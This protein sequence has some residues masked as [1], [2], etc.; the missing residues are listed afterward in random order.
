M[1]D[2]P[3]KRA[4]AEARRCSWIRAELGVVLLEGT[5]RRRGS[6][7]RLRWV[8]VDFNTGRI[9]WRREHDKKRKEWVV[10]YPESL[11]AT[12]REFQRR[13]GT[14]GWARV[15]ATCRPAAVRAA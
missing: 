2:S 13:L 15:P 3:G 4:L 5:G 8:D 10:A 11:L 1:A 7:T 14:V 9:T 12:V 6:V